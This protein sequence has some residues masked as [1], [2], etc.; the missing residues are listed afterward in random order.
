MT[1]N[2]PE[3][4]RIIDQ[5]RELAGAAREMK[6]AGA[7]AFD[8]EADSMYHFREKVC[9]I[10]IATSDETLVVDPLKLA[11]LSPL[12]P[13]M[14]DPR[15]R[16][17]MHGADY[18][19]RSLYRDFA[20]EVHNLFDTELASRFLGIRE[21]GLD[22]VLQDRFGVHL[23]KKYQRKD[24]SKRPLPEAMMDY[25]AHDVHYLLP[26]AAMLE[27]KLRQKGRLAWVLEEC[28][29]LRRVRPPEQNNA[30]LY[31]SFKGAGRLRPRHL[32]AL[33]SL[34]QLRRRLAESKDRPLFK[35]FS[36]KSLLTL[37]TTM[38]LNLRAL[39]QTDALSPKQ[40]KLHGSVLLKAIRQA[41]ELPDKKL[42]AYPRHKAPRM[43]ARVPER[44]TALK[45]WRDH[46]AQALD[47]DPGL[48]L[49]KALM[50]AIAL[51]HPKTLADLTDIPDL[52][53]WRRKAFGR[54]IINVMKQVR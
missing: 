39:G 16:K 50:Q 36:N 41:Q 44:V 19:I 47:L 51:Q 18:D 25:A 35:V 12:K 17:V 1:H 30:P 10:Q 34:L 52:R 6:K 54:D 20:I 5:P 26:L 33:E 48:M 31:L 38:P 46:K 14:A 11:D 53:Q 21:S 49:S 7:I 3:G 40:I 2:N 43:T 8:L 28:D 4:Y 42:P 9:L 15:I 22:A 37:A 45:T 13:V 23:D 24:W 32:A 27:K 29:W